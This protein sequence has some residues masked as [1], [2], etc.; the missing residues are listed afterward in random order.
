MYKFLGFI[1]IM[2]LGLACISPS[3]SEV[4]SES[5][6]N[7]AL[8]PLKYHHPGLHVDLGVGL[9]AWPLP[10]DYDGDGG[11]DLVVLCP[12]TPY[13]GLYF[14]ENTAGPEVMMP[15][16]EAPVKIGAGL[17]NLQIS[18]VEGVPHLLGPGVE[19]ENFTEVGLTQPRALYPAEKLEVGF[20]KIRFK[21]WKYVDYEGDGD[22]DVIVGMDEWGD[23]GWDNAYD[24][25]GQWTNGPLHGYIYLLENVKG[26][27]ENRGRLTA[28]GR[29]ID[30]YGG[31]SANMMD[32]D[33][34]GDLDLICGEFLDRF[35]WFENIGTR[36][37]PQFAEGR[38]LANENG[39]IKMDLEMFIPSA[40]DWGG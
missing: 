33:G 40:V 8:A 23:Y 4:S 31:P 25:L 20:T 27:Y 9:W 17:K 32:F 6:E 14:F 22:L 10:M 15:V 39:L 30:V 1:T 38:W 34:D 18:F 13:R 3:V 2:V 5:D 26:T 35:T 12:D 36:S 29:I 21:Q 37:E 11:L 19:Y 7:P 16:F 24:S 28:N